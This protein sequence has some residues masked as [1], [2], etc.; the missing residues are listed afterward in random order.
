MAYVDVTKNL[1]DGELTVTDNSSGTITVALDE[2]DLSYTISQDVREIYDRGT[3]DHL[4][5]GNDMPTDVSFSVKFVG[6]TDDASGGA[7]NVS[8]YEAMTGTGGA[9]G[10]TY[11]AA[12]SLSSAGDVNVC[13]LSFVI[14]YGSDYETITFEDFFHTSIEFSEGDDYNTLRVSGRAMD[15]LPYAEYTAG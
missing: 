7:A 11:T 4:R 5:A 1:R 6:L 3:M 8:L 14:T 2:G 15:V 10:W 13:Q 12:G 9:S